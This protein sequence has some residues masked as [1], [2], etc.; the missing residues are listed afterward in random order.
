MGTCGV[1]LRYQSTAK[2]GALFAV[3]QKQMKGD[4][5]LV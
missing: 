5:Y 2:T 4:S 1:D 3:L